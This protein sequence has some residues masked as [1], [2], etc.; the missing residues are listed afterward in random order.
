MIVGRGYHA[1]SA[2][3][4]TTPPSSCVAREL[5]DFGRAVG[6]YDGEGAIATCRGS[7]AVHCDLRSTRE[8]RT[9]C[10]RPYVAT[11]PP[12]EVSRACGR[13]RGAPSP[14]HIAREG[15]A[16]RDRCHLHFHTAI[17]SIRR[18]RVARRFPHDDEGVVATA[19]PQMAQCD[20]SW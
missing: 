17:L 2:P 4:A 15:R 13:K 18:G 3:V 8:G 7:G 12:N 11:Y 5:T 14:S 16:C 20:R 9:C 10:D 1:S 6:R 19:N